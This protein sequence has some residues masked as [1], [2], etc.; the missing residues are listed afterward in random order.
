MVSWPP[1]P[2]PTGPLAR[3]LYDGGLSRASD[4]HFRH[5][6][7]SDT[8]A[9]VAFAL[10]APIGRPANAHACIALMIALPSFQ[11]FRIHRRATSVISVIAACAPQQ[12]CQQRQ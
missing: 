1:A 4:T 11:Y 12:S 2:W 3:P 7:L 5:A 8:R 9:L 6:L 10:F